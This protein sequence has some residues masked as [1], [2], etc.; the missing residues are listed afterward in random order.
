MKTLSLK[1]ILLFN[2]PNYQNRYLLK[3]LSIKISV[4]QIS[5]F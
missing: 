2:Q 4:Y 3:V 1:V 5:I